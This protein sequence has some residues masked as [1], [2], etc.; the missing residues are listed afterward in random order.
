MLWLL[1]LPPILAGIVLAGRAHSRYLDRLEAVRI[2]LLERDPLP[3]S[4]PAKAKKR[5][6]ADDAAQECGEVQGQGGRG[7][8]GVPSETF[9]WSQRSATSPSSLAAASDR[10]IETIELFHN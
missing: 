4:L 2:V 10:P 9:F 8:R 6:L 1:V 3:G 5:G 7:K